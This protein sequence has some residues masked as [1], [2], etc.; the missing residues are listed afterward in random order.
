MPRPGMWK[1]KIQ[2]SPVK[3][4]QPFFVGCG[5]E[6]WWLWDVQFRTPEKAVVNVMKRMA[7]TFFKNSQSYMQQWAGV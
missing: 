6:E 3:D 4:N 1:D 5:R 2:W 7:W